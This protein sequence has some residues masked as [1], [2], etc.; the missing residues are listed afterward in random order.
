MSTIKLVEISER[1]RTRDVPV[2][3]FTICTATARDIL[4][5]AKDR[6]A[7]AGTLDEPSLT[8]A[9]MT[10]RQGITVLVD[11]MRRY[12]AGHSLASTR[13]RKVMLEAGLDPGR[14]GAP[15]MNT[16][17]ARRVFGGHDHRTG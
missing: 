15:V 2:L 6:W 9:T 12:T 11:S 13:A 17:P 4:Q 5:A 1:R 7:A 8:N 14:I 3:V 16:A 10:R